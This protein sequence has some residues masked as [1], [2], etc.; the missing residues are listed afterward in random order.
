MRDTPTAHSLGRGWDDNHATTAGG[1]AWRRKGHTVGM[2]DDA[3][4]LLNLRLLQSQAASP[5]RGL[6][7]RMA[8]D[9]ADDVDAR[10]RAARTASA[11]DMPIRL[12]ELRSLS[13]TAGAGALSAG[14]AVLEQ[15]VE[16]GDT[17]T[18]DDFV[19]VSA[20]AVRS[21]D[22]LAAWWGTH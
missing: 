20:L 5:H 17:A 9:W 19:I 18:D 22:A 1:H 10:I 8:R 6:F 11:A 12:H 15:R 7:A 4:D 16:G 3:G 14:V 2:L 21:R 13:H